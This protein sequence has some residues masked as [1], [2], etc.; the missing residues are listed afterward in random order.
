MLLCI[1]AGVVFV[2]DREMRNY[3]N[4]SEC[5]DYLGPYSFRYNEIDDQP[6]GWTQYT[7]NGRVWVVSSQDGHSEVVELSI[8]DDNGSAQMS[9]CDDIDRKSG[10]IEF[11]WQDNS[12]NCNSNFLIHDF[13]GG[14]AKTILWLNMYEDP[15]FQFYG[16]SG[17]DEIYDVNS[18]VIDTEADKWYHIKIAVF[19]DDPILG[20]YW[21]IWINGILG[22]YREGTQGLLHQLP[23]R[24]NTSSFDTLSFLL[25]PGKAGD[26][27]YVDAV[28]YS[29]SDENYYEGRNSYVSP[30][31]NYLGTYS[32]NNDSCYTEPEDW[33]CD[34]DENSTI[35]V[36][37]A[38]DGHKK[39][40]ALCDISKDASADKA[41]M[42]QTI[43]DDQEAGAI[44]FWCR[45]DTDDSPKYFE[46]WDT[47][48][49]T[50]AFRLRMFDGSFKVGTNTLYSSLFTQIQ[51]KKDVWYH[52]SVVFHCT[53]GV[54]ASG[55]VG[56]WINGIQAYWRNSLKLD[57]IFAFENKIEDENIDKFGF[58]VPGEM[59]QH[60]LFVD[61]IGFSWDE[62]YNRNNNTLF[63][64]HYIGE[65]TFTNEDVLD[66]S[67]WDTYTADGSIMIVDAGDHDDVVE[68][69]TASISGEVY[70]ETNV[71][72]RSSN[73]I[74]FYCRADS[75]DYCANLSLWDM[76]ATPDAK[77]AITFL[78]FDEGKFKFMDGD[79]KRTLQYFVD[80]QGDVDFTA[81]ADRWYHIRLQF[82]TDGNND[83]IHIWIDGVSAKY[84]TSTGLDTE[85]LVDHI[86]M[87]RFY[88]S[89]SSGSA[90]FDA[91][92]FNWAMGYYDGRNLEF[93]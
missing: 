33:V 75:N 36:A 55:E 4:T 7:D 21:V 87:I 50:R 60:I 80:G 79:F 8:N 2:V 76:D 46:I 59:G 74:E 10:I 65:Y 19:C 61:A 66:P 24:D 81:A 93:E 70:M 28:D 64:K 56:L 49:N 88:T 90:F 78:M 43:V 44:D 32:F 69:S 3:S 30:P 82:F 52:I 14:S 67:D 40:A 29:W 42:Y 77:R 20:D 23:F 68:L 25:G 92:D 11:W 91:I 86:N 84:D 41:Y 54:N 58:R 12:D 22:L 6:E 16:P 37:S 27:L 72:N 83:F 38:V 48:S 18:N 39:V 63:S 73:T 45:S 47:D 34:T 15:C 17:W 1:I 9:K 13:Q 85:N 71:G 62:E 53:S 26:A 5:Y 35:W 31:K 57:S 89:G 51:S